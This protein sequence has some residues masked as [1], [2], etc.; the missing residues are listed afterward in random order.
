[1]STPLTDLEAAHAMLEQDRRRMSEWASGWRMWV[2][3][4]AWPFI[5]IVGIPTVLTLVLVLFGGGVLGFLLFAIFGPSALVA[6]FGSSAVFPAWLI[7]ERR[8]SRV[9][10]L[11]HL[12]WIE[13]K[14]KC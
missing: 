14:A 10:Y 6:L 2:G 11:D 5:V 3:L 4:V 8:R 7:R 9:R 13:R 12:A 1:M